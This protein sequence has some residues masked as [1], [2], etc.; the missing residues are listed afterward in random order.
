MA[1]KNEPRILI[2]GLGNPLRSDD[3][4]GWRAAQ[5]L[6]RMNLPQPIQIIT[7]PQLTPELSLAASQ[8]DL[9]V[10]IDASQADAPGKIR[11]EP[12]VPAFERGAFSHELSPSGV[13]GLAEELY[14][15]A[16]QGYLVSMGAKCFDHGERLS[17]SVI[18]ALPQLI[19][20]VTELVTEAARE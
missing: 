20:Q 9:V 19:T 17:E 14:G 16:A 7:Q 18:A 11:C 6:S 10:F 2:I 3:G 12:V 5:E 8:A 13:L 15:T 4:L 1:S